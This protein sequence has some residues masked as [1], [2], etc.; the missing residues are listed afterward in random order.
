MAT[1]SDSQRNDLRYYFNCRP[2]TDF[3]TLTPSK[4]QN[5]YCCPICGSGTGQNKTGA[6]SILRTTA[7]T[8]RVTCFAHGCFGSHGED[9]IGALRIIYQMTEREI[10]EK[11]GLLG[12]MGTAAAGK[13]FSSTG[14]KPTGK[15]PSEDEYA[16]KLAKLTEE[17]S[18]YLQAHYS[19]APVSELLEYMAMRG[20]NENTVK[21][22]LFGYD[23]A[24]N[25]VVI[26]TITPSGNWTYEL[27]TTQAAKNSSRPKYEAAKGIEGKGLFNASVLLDESQPLIAITEG[28]I[29]AASFV[30]LGLPAVAMS[31]VSGADMLMAYVKAHVIGNHKLENRAYLIATDNDEAGEECAEKLK[32]FF[33]RQNLKSERMIFG[34]AGCKDVNEWLV[35]DRDSLTN[36]LQWWRDNICAEEESFE[37]QPQEEPQNADMQDIENHKIANMIPAFRDYINGFRS[38]NAMSTG[39]KALDSAI[40]GGLLPRFYVIGAQTSVGKTTFVLQIAD[41]VASLGHDVIVFSLEMSKEDLIARSISRL[42]GLQARLMNDDTGKY[43]RSEL[44]ILDGRRYAAYDSDQLAVIEAAFVEYQRMI[45]KYVYVYEGKHT[46]DDIRRIVVKHIELTGKVPLVV[47]DYLQIVAPPDALRRATVRDQIN[48][49]IDILANMKRELKCPVLGISSFNRMSYGTVADVSSLKES[50]ELEYSADCV[51]TL[52]LSANHAAEFNDKRYNNDNSVK[53]GH[54]S[55]MR[56]SVRKIKLTLHKNRGNQYGQTIDFEYTPK[57][58]RF[59]EV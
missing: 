23:K 46:A 42:T 53:Q 5:K 45:A 11:Y 44:D 33:E 50:G 15:T 56:E 14:E 49:A 57:Y 12:G 17:R 58:N 3:M 16:A 26:P 41:N 28:A 55:A 22:L 52:E 21:Q 6:L 30:E 34:E 31:S 27:R 20:I 38:L 1:I 4:G 40:G 54:L 7:G 47:V 51:M 2:L 24:K 18:K 8:Y 10:F 32:G 13:A 9:T 48:Y 25:A 37:D 36:E 59:E 19:A 39:F 43:A 35:K 29:D